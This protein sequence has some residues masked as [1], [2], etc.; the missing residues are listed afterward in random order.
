MHWLDNIKLFMLDLDGTIY[1]S[2][3]LF[4]QSPPFIEKI[5]ST[6]RE[7]VYLTNNSSKSYRNYLDKLSGMGLPVT[8]ETML[9]SGLAT[10]MFLEEHFRGK[11]IYLMGTKALE[12]ELGEFD[13]TISTTL[14][15]EI[16]CIVAGFD[17]ELHYG[18][19]QDMCTLLERGLPFFGTNPDMVCP[20]KGGRYIP[21]C[22]AMC[23]MLE[24]AT[25]RKPEYIGK[26]SA[27]LVDIVATRFGVAK[28][29]I[30]MVGDRLYTDIA[31][32]KNAGIKSIL[33]LSGEA[34]EE[35]LKS[36]PFQPDLVVESVGELGTM[37]K[38]L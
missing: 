27:T 21:D 30:A 23:Q 38:E 33:V 28:E 19:L 15:D 2:D 6:G 32:G 35:D 14:S 11:T 29:Q 4:E 5:T 8:K 25:G 17:M 22:G 26:P 20:L 31:L 13:I 12:Q 18:K 34:T 1:L 36:S 37:L 3:D 24:H 16:D 7:Y 9:T 10:G